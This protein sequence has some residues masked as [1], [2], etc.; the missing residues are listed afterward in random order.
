MLSVNGKR[1]NDL[2]IVLN[3][4]N[5]QILVMPR[6]GGAPLATLPYNKILHATYVRARDPKWAPKLA[7]P[8][9]DLEVGNM[10]RTPRHW[11]VLQG[12]ENYAILRVED[13]MVNRL[14][15]TFEAR[16]GLKVDRVK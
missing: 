8:P 6:T 16:T 14:L 3:F 15:D 10:L 1:T 4:A 13:N 7:G 11:L 2:E 12:A 5:G 9:A